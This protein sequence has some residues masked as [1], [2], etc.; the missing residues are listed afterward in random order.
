MYADQIR[1]RQALMNL[2]SNASKFTSNGTVTVS[3]VREQTADGEHLEFA[4]SDTGIGMSPEQLAKMFQEFSQANS[5]TTRKYGGT[6]LGLAISRR[7]CQMMGGD[8]SVES[9]LGRGSKFV[10]TLPVHVGDAEKQAR[11]PEA[12]RLRLTGSLQQAPLILV[13]D[14]DPPFARSS[15]VTSCAKDLRLPKRMAG[16]KAS[17]WRAN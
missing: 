10:I 17:G 13:V 12:S 7:F 3:A 2:V 14:D 8:I 6:G 9:E 15:D 16:V 4:V 5:S 11:T 1:V